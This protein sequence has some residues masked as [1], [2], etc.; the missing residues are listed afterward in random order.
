MTGVLHHFYTLWIKVIF[1]GVLNATEG[2][3][4]LFHLMLRNF[5]CVLF[6]RELLMLSLFFSLRTISSVEKMA[7]TV[8]CAS[9]RDSCFFLALQRANL[10]FLIP[11]S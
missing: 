4:E 2:E 3:G 6:V 9:L 1:S 10:T 7:P 8:A 5:K 11:Y